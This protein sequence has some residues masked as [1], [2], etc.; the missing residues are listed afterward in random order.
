MIKWDLNNDHQKRKDD[1]KKK[2]VSNT[3]FIY[4]HINKPEDD[5]RHSMTYKYI[6]ILESLSET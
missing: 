2:H 1:D 3:S 6:V 5:G 4:I